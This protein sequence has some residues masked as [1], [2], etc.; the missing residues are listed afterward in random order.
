MEES[1]SV[2]SVSI[3]AELKRAVPDL[4]LGVICADVVVEKKN[5]VVWDIL[6]RLGREAAAKYKLDM[7]SVN[8]R[9]QAARDAYRKLGKDP[10]RYRVSSEALLRRVLQGKGLYQVNNVVDINN[11]I[12]METLLSVGVYDRD[13]LKGPVVFGVGRPGESY[14]GIGK[15]TLN[16]AELPVFVDEVG[17]FGSPTSDSERAMITF[18]TRKV[19]MVIISFSGNLGGKLPEDLEKGKALLRNYAGGTNI[20]ASSV[21]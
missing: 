7:L 13:K 18:N 10:S 6:Q 4:C 20:T 11:I 16:I 8:P 12:S 14:R 19:L 17:P 3:A 21:V 1:Q 5:R 15:E 2:Y 9:L